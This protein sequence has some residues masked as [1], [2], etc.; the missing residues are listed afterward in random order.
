MFSSLYLLGPQGGT[1]A[2]PR[3]RKPQG[4]AQD[5]R[6]VSPTL[7]EDRTGLLFGFPDGF[8]APVSR[9]KNP[10]SRRSQAPGARNVADS[11]ETGPNIMVEFGAVRRGR[12]TLPAPHRCPQPP[13]YETDSCRANICATART[14]RDAVAVHYFPGD[15]P[16]KRR[17]IALAHRA[18]LRQLGEADPR[19][20]A[21]RPRADP[22]R[23]SAVTSACGLT[24]LVDA[25]QPPARQRPAR[26]RRQRVGA[27]PAFAPSPSGRAS[28]TS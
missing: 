3:H 22:E 20:D 6:P 26:H 27:R 7:L 17:S 28:A 4:R 23:L 15:D 16:T 5:L 13:E 25:G 24:P 18:A 9:W 19:S 21:L 12:P 8:S 2:F 1:Q 10:D 14:T 11:E